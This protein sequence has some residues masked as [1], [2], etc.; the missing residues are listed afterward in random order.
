MQNLPIVASLGSLLFD[1]SLLLLAVFQFMYANTRQSGRYPTAI[2][3]L[4]R[5]L[6]TRIVPCY[7]VAWRM[8]WTGMERRL[9]NNL[10]DLG[11]H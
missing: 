2:E 11:N 5:H 1:P 8:T 7:R 9:V 3:L 4:R 10:A 6:S